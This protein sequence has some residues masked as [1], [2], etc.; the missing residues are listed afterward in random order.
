MIERYVELFDA[1]LSASEIGRR[2]GKKANTIRHHLIKN[3]RKMR[4]RSNKPGMT[5]IDRFFQFVDKGSDGECWLWRGLKD[6]HGYGQFFLRGRK[7]TAQRASY[8]LFV[9]EIPVSEDDRIEVDHRCKNT[10]CVNPHHLR[11]LPKSINLSERVHFN[12]KKT[13]CLRGHPL[14]GSNLYLESGGGRRCIECRRIGDKRRREARKI[15]CD[16]GGLS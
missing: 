1:G 8:Q 10:S 4:N 14:S 16:N 3:G 11:L 13:H 5:E 15:I 7:Q 6:K 9:G 2:F 12:S